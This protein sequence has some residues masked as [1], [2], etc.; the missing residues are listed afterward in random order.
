MPYWK[1]IVEGP[2]LTPLPHLALPVSTLWAVF[3]SGPPTSDVIPRSL[4]LVPHCS[5][6]ADINMPIGKLDKT[7]GKG[8]DY[9]AGSVTMESQC[10][11]TASRQDVKS[12]SISKGIATSNSYG[13]GAVG[14]ETAIAQKEMR[15]DKQSLSIDRGV[16]G[17]SL[18][19]P[20]AMG[21]E[22]CK[23]VQQLASGKN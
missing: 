14:V 16:G 10:S 5:K 8:A 11:Q 13:P 3:S 15:S 22:K 20:G 18:V 9:S 19:G 7:A 1:L 17:T 4:V 21:V 12:L 23:E 6:R 2:G